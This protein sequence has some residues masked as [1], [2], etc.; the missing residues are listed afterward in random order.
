MQ[1]TMG[2]P[3]PN[4]G[5]GITVSSLN[6]I[7]SPAALE[8]GSE[9]FDANPIGAGPFTLKSWIRQDKMELSKNPSYWNAPKPYLD[10][11]TIRTVLDSAQRLNT[12]QADG[13]DIVVDN[14]ADNTQKAEAAGYG[15]YQVM[16][17]GGNGFALNFRKA[18]F[19]DPKV[20]EAFVK[21]ID[22]AAAAMPALHHEVLAS[23]G[24]PVQ[25][26]GREAYRS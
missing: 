16:L 21:A 19:D 18:P 23:Q 17:N 15:T 11:L 14:K 9:A 5:Q 22:D 6:W 10:S 20:R 26:T 4:F 8:K 2:V 24:I 7:A 25:G 13:V 1:F 3:N 12:L